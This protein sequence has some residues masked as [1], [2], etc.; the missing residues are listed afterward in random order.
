MGLLNAVLLNP[1]TIRACSTLGPNFGPPTREQEMLRSLLPG[2]S[3]LLK[4][5]SNS[6]IYRYNS[7]TNVSF[8]GCRDPQFVTR[9]AP[10]DPEVYSFKIG[11]Q[12]KTFSIDEYFVKLVKQKNDTWELYAL[13]KKAGNRMFTLTDALKNLL[14]HN[15]DIQKIEIR[16][17]KEFF[18][19]EGIIFQDFDE[20]NK[21][22]PS[23]DVKGIVEKMRIT[24]IMTS[25]GFELST[26]SHNNQGRIYIY[27]RT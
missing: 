14:R 8:V 6:L 27:I 22:N 13:T 3:I 20:I 2:D 5:G 9:Q 4:E 11:D 24:E 7:P 23:L 10:D 15:P 21:N 25:V 19:Y 12:I 18:E 26:A 16:P 1:S 17:V